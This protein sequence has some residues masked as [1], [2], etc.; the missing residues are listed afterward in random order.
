MGRIVGC[1]LALEDAGGAVLGGWL[2][3]EVP[4]K[5]GLELRSEAHHRR[6]PFNAWEDLEIHKIRAAEVVLLPA[7]SLRP[8]A[9]L[10]PGSPF[11]VAAPFEVLNL[12]LDSAAPHPTV[13]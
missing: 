9:D 4:H 6:I 10:V 2:V 5:G 13:Q 3:L 8:L 7:P 12:R 1:C 11:A